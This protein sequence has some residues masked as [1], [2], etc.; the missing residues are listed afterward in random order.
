MANI[1]VKHLHDIGIQFPK[2]SA[3]VNDPQYSRAQEC[4]TAVVMFF[5]DL[6]LIQNFLH[7][8]W[9]RYQTGEIDLVTATITTTAA[10]RRVRQEEKALLEWTALIQTDLESP[11]QKLKSFDEQE[12]GYM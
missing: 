7:E 12:Q 1:C 4:K 6:H 11:I 8:T 2:N 3:E 10:V 9:Q 5:D